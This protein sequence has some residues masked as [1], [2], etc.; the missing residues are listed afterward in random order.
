MLVIIYALFQLYE[1][2]AEP[3]KLWECQL[4]IIDVSGHDD[5]DLIQGI[6]SNIIQEGEFLQTNQFI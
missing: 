6:W 4:A 2:F 1:E 3:Y 5:I